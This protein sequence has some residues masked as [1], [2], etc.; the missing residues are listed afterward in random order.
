MRQA[1]HAL[2]AAPLIVA[3]TFAALLRRSG[4]ARYAVAIGL[5]LITG[6]GVFG[7]SRPAIT[8]AVP[9]VP[10]APLAQS[11]FTAAVDTG[12]ALTEPVAVV[13][14]AMSFRAVVV[15]EPEAWTPVKSPPT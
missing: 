15:P 2:L 14:A 11:E 6:I 3:A 8:V 7:T 9:P 5:A 4:A 1:V 13:R 12:H 10:I